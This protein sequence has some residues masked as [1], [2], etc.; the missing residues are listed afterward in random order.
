MILFVDECLCCSSGRFVLKDSILGVNKDEGTYWILYALDYLSRD[1]A[2]PVTY[3]Q[4]RH[5]I[6]VID[7]D[8]DNQTRERIKDIYAPTNTSDLYANR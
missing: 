5:G 3:E 1:H 6:D 2:S 7:Y 4:Y 8:M